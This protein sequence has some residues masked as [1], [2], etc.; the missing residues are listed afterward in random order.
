M[1]GRKEP[2][3]QERALAQ[4]IPRRTTDR[5]PLDDRPVPEAA[6]TA[7]MAAT[8]REGGWVRFLREGGETRRSRC[9]CCFP[10]P[11][12]VSAATP[13]T[14]PSSPHGD[15][16]GWQRAYRMLLRLGYG[17]TGPTSRRRPLERTVTFVRP[18]GCQGA[19]AA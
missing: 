4:A 16:S 8:E 14:L 9:R 13:S 10:T 2:S 7:L 18:L 5:D 11:T 12:A 1:Q 6:R 17:H 3:E 19:A 15:A